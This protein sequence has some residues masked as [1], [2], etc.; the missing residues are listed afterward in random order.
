[1]GF[2]GVFFDEFFVY[3]FEESGYVFEG[4]GDVEIGFFYVFVFYFGSFELRIGKGISVVELN[5]SFEYVGVGI[6][7]LCDNGFGN[8]VLFDG[9]N[10]F[11]FFDIIDFIEEDEDFVFRIGLVM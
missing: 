4:F 8:D 7:S 1:M 5:F 3:L 9:I 10:D 11:V 2:D 6:D